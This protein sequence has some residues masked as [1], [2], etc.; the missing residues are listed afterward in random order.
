MSLRIDSISK[1]L[2]EEIFKQLFDLCMWASPLGEELLFGKHH[3]NRDLNK[4]IR[5]LFSHFNLKA[6]PVLVWLAHFAFVNLQ[7]R[8]WAWGDTW[9]ILPFFCLCNNSIHCHHISTFCCKSQ[10]LLTFVLL[11]AF[12][13]FPKATRAVFWCMVCLPQ[14]TKIAWVLESEPSYSPIYYLVLLFLNLLIIHT[15]KEIPFGPFKT[16]RLADLNTQLQLL[17]NIS[18]LYWNGPFNVIFNLIK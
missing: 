4:R 17:L 12:L 2:S 3:R 10:C 14:I 1:N 16:A 6:V 15:V 8:G 7:R 13:H 18:V 5:T 9:L 11:N